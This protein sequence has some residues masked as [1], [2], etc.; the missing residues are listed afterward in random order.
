MGIFAAVLRLAGQVV[1]PHDFLEHGLTYGDLGH[2]LL[3]HG[4]LG[5]KLF[6]LLGLVYLESTIDLAPA[7]IGL[8]ADANLFEGFGDGLVVGGLYV[9]PA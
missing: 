2:Q 8:F 5:F 7:V 1:S 6:E 3:K 4:I 9:N